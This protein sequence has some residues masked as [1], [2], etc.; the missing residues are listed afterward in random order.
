MVLPPMIVGHEED[1]VVDVTAHDQPRTLQW[2]SAVVDD[3]GALAT[4]TDGVARD[5]VAG[6]SSDGGVVAA[7]DG[8]ATPARIQCCWPPW[9]SS[10]STDDG[11]DWCA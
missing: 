8:D 5:A 11:W 6:A 10:A 4:G 2:P 9:H 1:D 7:A 3:A